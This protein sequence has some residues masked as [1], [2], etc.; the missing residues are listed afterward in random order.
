MT[1]ACEQIKLL[2]INSGY[3]QFSHAKCSLVHGKELI[4][5][6]AINPLKIVGVGKSIQNDMLLEANDPLKHTSMYE[7]AGG[8]WKQII[9]QEYFFNFFSFIEQIVKTVTMKEDWEMLIE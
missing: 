2:H 3:I 8:S 7:K 9:I 6:V 1:F 4:E 5:L